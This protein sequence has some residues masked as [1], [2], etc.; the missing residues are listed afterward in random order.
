MK[1]TKT[2]IGALI[3]VILVLAIDATALYWD[4]IPIVT[5]SGLSDVLARY[6]C[7]NRKVTWQVTGMLLRWSAIQ[8]LAF[9]APGTI[10]S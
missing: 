9:T 8:P 7:D 4:G 10:R 6:R 1:F 3:T 2:A 5:P